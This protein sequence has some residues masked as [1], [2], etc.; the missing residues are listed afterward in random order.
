MTTT[1]ITGANR[2]I[3]LELTKQ[4]ASGGDTVLACCR[5]PGSADAL[6]AIEGV[7]V[8]PLDVTDGTS[9]KALASTLE[10][11]PI[12]ILI[13]N[14]GIMGGEHQ[15][16][17]DMDYDAWAQTFLVNTMGPFR[18]ITALMENLKSAE[19]PK[20]IT[21]TSQMGMLSRRSTGAHA[22]RSSKAA[23]NK[24]MQVLANELEGDTIIVCPVHPGWVRTDMGGPSASVGV[25]KSASGLIKLIAGLT[26]K[27]SGRFFQ[28]DG[29]ELAW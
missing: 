23:A 4:Y 20:I 17:G 21:V 14:A 18:V 27:E 3:G 8:L 6:N 9:V 28:Y 22:Y 19:T 1:L 2:G 11:R 7:E 12:D 16:Q 24:V 29:E 25:E 13:N 15:T 10:G 26:M 5:N